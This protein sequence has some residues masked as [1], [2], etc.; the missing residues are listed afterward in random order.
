MSKAIKNLL[1]GLLSVGI[2]AVV[3]QSLE[4][5]MLVVRECHNGLVL[6]WRLGLLL[7]KKF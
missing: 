1:L 7:A 3:R 4:N 5:N 6:T 2:A